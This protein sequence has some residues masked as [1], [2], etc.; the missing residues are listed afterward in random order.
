MA[1]SSVVSYRNWRLRDHTQLTRD[2]WDSLARYFGD[3]TQVFVNDPCFSP[4]C[5]GFRANLMVIERE[6]VCPIDP[7][8][9]GVLIVDVPVHVLLRSFHYVWKGPGP[10]PA[11]LEVVLYH[12]TDPDTPYSV[13]FGPPPPGHPNGFYFIDRHQTADPFT[14]AG[15]LLSFWGYGLDPDDG[16][17]TPIVSQPVKD[18]PMVIAA[19]L[20]QLDAP[21]EPPTG[22]VV[23]HMFFSYMS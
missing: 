3:H 9:S 18:Q 15:N 20:F 17:F 5:F 12:Y 10:H 13:V 1:R 19:I 6:I 22:P 16:E 7:D 11:Q 21:V 4:S 23:L 8:L 14:A 2:Y